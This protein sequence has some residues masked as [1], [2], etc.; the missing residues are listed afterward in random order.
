MSCI[1]RRISKFVKNSNEPRVDDHTI[2]KKKISEEELPIQVVI[3]PTITFEKSKLVEY[4][5][6]QFPIIK[7]NIRNGN[8]PLCVACEEGH[9]DVV[10]LLIENG[11]NVNM[12]DRMH[13]KPLY[14]AC[15]NGHLDV[16]KW[17]ILKGSEVD[18]GSID[19][20]ITPLYIACNEGHFDVVKLL[21]K[22]RANIHVKDRWGKTPLYYACEK[23]YF[24]IAKFLIKNGANVNQK[25]DIGDTP[26]YYA[27]TN[28]HFKIVKLL[29]E[30]G[31]DVNE[32]D[33][34]C[35]ICL[36]SLFEGKIYLT[37]CKHI[38][39]HECLRNSIKVSNK[40]KCPL[41]RGDLSRNSNL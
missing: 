32:F 28:G 2:C 37:S 12:H 30:K 36:E 18:V 16:A 7:E 6:K 31:V 29:I 33:E 9:L 20:N 15:K 10:K 38:F 19:Y 3:P 23:G 8:R 4:F 40:Y 5:T 27:Y 22:R 21:V 1:L 25:D 35:P 11:A 34:N 14:Y 24:D 13:N 26:L 41:C 17:L 39:H